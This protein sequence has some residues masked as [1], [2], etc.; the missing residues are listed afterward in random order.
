[1]YVQNEKVFFQAQTRKGDL[2]GTHIKSTKKI[3]VYSGNVRAYVL[4]KKSWDH[5]AEQLPPVHSWGK[6]FAIV[7]TPMRT[8]TGDTIRFISAKAG[9]EVKLECSGG[10]S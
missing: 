10:F 8:N 5:L 9:T 4:P 7:P 1:M 3:G 6:K 2:T